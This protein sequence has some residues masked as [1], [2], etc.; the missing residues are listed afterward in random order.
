MMRAY[1]KRLTSSDAKERNAAARAWSIWEGATSHLRTDPHYVAKFRDADYAAAF[2]RIECHYFVNGGYL[3]ADDQLLRDVPKI[4][5]IPG[6]IVQGRYD[7][8]CPMR[9]AWASAPRLAGGRT[10][11]GARCRPLR[12]RARHRQGT[13]QGHGQVSQNG[14][15]RASMRSTPLLA[16]LLCMPLPV[17]AAAPAPAQPPAPPRIHHRAGR[18][19]KAQLYARQ[20]AACHGASQ[21]GGEAG[22]AL[23]G[24][25]FQR[26]WA[27]RPW[28]E[29]FEQTRRTMPVT[30]PGGPAPLA[31]RRPGRTAAVGQRHRHRAQRRLSA[32]G[33]APSRAADKPAPD[34][35]WLHHRGDRGQPQLLAAGTDRA[36][37]PGAADRGLALALGQLRQR[38]LPQPRSDAADGARRAVRHRRR[39]AQRGRHRCEERRDAVD[40]SPR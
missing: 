34:T 14:A 37:Q 15:E 5:H 12:L 26:K 9:S 1:Y 23:R 10:G 22:P 32:S 39:L 17:L 3:E 13:A 11:G 40:A 21:E 29:L 38:H 8:V 7:V 25:V 16:L 6:V 33:V 18:G 30:Q 20:C 27:T 19:R 28:Q 2:A 24:E 4:R 31:V 35:E 36:R